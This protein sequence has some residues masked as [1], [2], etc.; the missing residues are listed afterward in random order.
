VLGENSMSW[1]K[2][3]CKLNKINKYHTNIL[4]YGSE[5]YAMK[6]NAIRRLKKAEYTML[7]WMCRVTLSDRIWAAQLADRLKN[8]CLEELVSL[9]R[10]WAT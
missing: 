7:R 4:V 2:F 8:V 9:R 1:P 3:W 6:V 5:I 10:V